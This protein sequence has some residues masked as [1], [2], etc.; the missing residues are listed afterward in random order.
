MYRFSDVIG[1]D[2]ATGILRNSVRN[3][4]YANAY[5]FHG[6]DGVG[7]QTTAL[8]FAAALN[9]LERKDGDACGTCEMCRRIEIKLPGSVVVVEPEKQTLS[10]D[11]L[12]G[13]KRDAYLKKTGGVKVYIVKG[14][15]RARREASNSILKILEEPPADTV[16]VLLAENYYRLLPTIRSRSVALRFRQLSTSDIA[17][18]LTD[19]YNVQKERALTVA[20]LS[21]GSISG[22]LEV[23]DGTRQEIEGLIGNLTVLLKRGKFSEVSRFIRTGAHDRKTVSA[24]LKCLLEKASERL[25]TLPALA[26]Q[27][28]TQALLDSLQLLR[29]NVNPSL[30]LESLLL[31]LNTTGKGLLDEYRSKSK[32]T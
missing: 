3:N 4:R 26:S 23:L 32:S 13:I 1:Q 19:R 14:M 27:E 29:S 10:I 17:K 20:R 22:A 28:S 25:E 12:R 21:C 16:I 18:I 24:I 15:D 30:V 6:P 2:V 9:C 31:T 7:K 11:Q 8:A 5:I